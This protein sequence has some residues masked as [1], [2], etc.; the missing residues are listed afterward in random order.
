MHDK[1]CNFT[2]GENWR[3]LPIVIMGG[4]FQFKKLKNETNQTVGRSGTCNMA[5]LT[6]QQP[7]KNA[8]DERDMSESEKSFADRVS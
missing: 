3:K 8:L 1:L 4:A 7:N 5:K 2:L 6:Y